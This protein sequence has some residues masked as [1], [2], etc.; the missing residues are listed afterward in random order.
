[1]LLQTTTGYLEEAED[2]ID[3][4]H[5]KTRCRCVDGDG[6]VPLRPKCHDD[7]RERFFSAS[8]PPPFH[9]HEQA[10]DTRCRQHN[11]RHVTDT[12]LLAGG[13]QRP[14]SAQQ[15]EARKNQQ[16]SLSFDPMRRDWTG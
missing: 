8:P 14:I 5:A 9:G 13:R 7:D 1:M 6:C 16:S 12:R 3:V 4:P 11:M 10:R 15:H 2:Y